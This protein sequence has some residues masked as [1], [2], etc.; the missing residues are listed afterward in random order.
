MASS[1]ANPKQSRRTSC[2][3]REP[4]TEGE[5]NRFWPLTWHINTLTCH[6]Y[7]ERTARQIK[8][9]TRVKM[10][11]N[12]FLK[13]SEQVNCLPKVAKGQS[14]HSR[15]G[16]FSPVQFR[17]LQKTLSRGRVQKGSEAEEQMPSQDSDNSNRNRHHTQRHRTHCSRSP[18][19]V[20]SCWCS[21]WLLMWLALLPKPF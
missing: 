3:H 9:C 2:T 15:P 21:L 1:Q 7:P 12:A 6:N 20:V 18:D 5:R 19:K 17:P 16:P 10:S 8:S 4:Q 14:L 13:V 11:A